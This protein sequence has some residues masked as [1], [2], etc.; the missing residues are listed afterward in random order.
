V[1]LPGEELAQQ[2]DLVV[3]AIPTAAATLL[4]PPVG[5][6]AV[7]GETVH[8]GGSDLDLERLA[9]VGDDH[10]MQGPI[11]VRLRPR[12]IVV[13]LLRDCLPDAVDGAERR[14]AVIDG[15]DDDAQSAQVLDL[16]QAQALAPHLAANAEQVLRPAAEF[17]PDPGA[18][19]LR[20]QALERGL[21]ELLALDA[22]LFELLRQP[23]VLVRPEEPE[24]QVLELPLELPET[25]PIGEWRQHVERLAADRRIGHATLRDM[26]P[27]RL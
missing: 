26:L 25:Q 5:G 22:A 17:R 11:A 12:N 19:K 16:G 8:L 21:D 24:R 2:G 27:Q 14:V 3:M 1:S 4:V 15:R 23:L 20:A 6:D 13:V 10:G 7:L 18:L 9:V